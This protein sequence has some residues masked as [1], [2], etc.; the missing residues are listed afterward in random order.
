MTGRISK[1]SLFITLFLVL[2][3]SNLNA[4]E[5]RKSQFLSELGYMI[6]PA[7]YS[8]PGIGEGLMIFGS[9]N[10][11][12][13]TYIDI[14]GYGFTGD[15]EGSGFGISD[16]HLI[17]ETLI[18]SIGT[19]NIKRATVMNYAKRG[20]D[21]EKE[22]YN[23]LEASDING[24]HTE[25][26]VSF[27]DRMLE[28]YAEYFYQ[29]VKLDRVR[30]SEGEIIVD[31]DDP[32]PQEVKNYEFGVLLDYTDDRLDPRS[33]IRLNISRLQSPSESEFDP[34][35]YSI[36]YNV[37]GFIPIGKFST[38][39]INFF[40]SD[41]VVTREGET[42]KGEIMSNLGMPCESLT[43]AALIQECIQSR[44]EL[45]NSTWAANKYGTA[46]SLGGRSRLRAYPGSRFIGAHT[47]F[48]GSEFR[49]N[50]TDEFTPFD[51][52]IMKD[53]RTA[54]Q[55]A[56]FYEVGSV[57]DSTSE[58]GQQI[59]DSYGSG[60]R[61]VTGSGLVYRIDVALGDEGSAVTM[62]ADYPW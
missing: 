4:L 9:G 57:S 53:I 2:L 41:A 7:P 1:A 42:D 35:Y 55:L 56:F 15:A 16:L 39:A 27:F 14:Y 23:F 19:E 33:G 44:D 12:L 59:R 32:E 40:R 28:V 37:T 51:I 46:S 38:F 47:L 3:S 11:L 58:L 43:N 13:D 29:S 60:V 54:V 8:I 31:I 50:L 45:V 17:P 36:D 5:R 10:N 49:W 52:W 48:L 6:V 61:I 30:D 24:N 20:L 22:E 21:T 26:T 62:I 34:E 25:L 18:F